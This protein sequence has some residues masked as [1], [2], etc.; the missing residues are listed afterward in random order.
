MGFDISLG[1]A[2]LA[3]LLSFVSPCVLPLVPP[4]LVFIA[5]V[6][7][8][9]LTAQESGSQGR[10][11]MLRALAFVLGFTSVFVALGASASVIGQFVSEYFEALSI[12][13]GLIIAL[14]GLHF[15]G[16]LRVPV[17]YREARFHL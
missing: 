17:L 6:S 10:R 8:E 11:V 3:G 14:M 13:A 9:E 16:V 2:F 7:L 4:Y 15:L 12:A 5:G 1:G